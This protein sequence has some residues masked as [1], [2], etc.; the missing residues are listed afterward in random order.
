MGLI[1]TLEDLLRAKGQPGVAGIWED[2]HEFVEA[3]RKAKQAGHNNMEA[4]SPYPLH[5]ID[6][7]IG[8]PRSIIPWV[9]FTF[10]SLGCLFGIW[11][12]WWTST[13]DWPINVG[14]K[15]M[16]SLAAFIPV[17]F[18]CTILLAALSSVAAMI[19]LNGL[20]KVDPPTIDPDLTCN[21]F[22]LWIPSAS[23]D[24]AQVKQ[25]FQSLGASDVK[26]AEF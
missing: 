16:W 25:L 19:G 7:A 15:P 26:E 18:E 24:S 11:F 17:I 2:E 6:D 13:T 5:G 3:A 21:K 10:G 9:T 12:T 22:A 14:G 20:P 23:A 1:D 8:I 4:I